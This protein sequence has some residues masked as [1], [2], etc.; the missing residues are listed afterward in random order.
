[1]KIIVEQCTKDGRWSARLETEDGANCF[2]DTVAQ[3]L[4]ELITHKKDELGIKL[5]VRPFKKN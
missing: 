3:A 2:G 5:D 1:M 4:A